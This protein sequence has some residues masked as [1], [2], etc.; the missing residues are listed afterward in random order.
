MK[1]ISSI[2]KVLS[3]SVS[4]TMILLAVRIIYTQKLV[5]GF[6]PWNLF[7]AF[8]PLIASSKLLNQ[9]RLN[10]KAVCLLMI[11]LLFFPNAPYLITDL[12][13]FTEREGCPPW[14]DLIL[15][16]SAT[17]NGI[18]IGALSLLQ[19]EKFLEKSFNHTKVR[20]ML[21]FFILLCGYGVYLG[22]FL[23]FNSWDIVTNPSNLAYFIKN[24]LLHPHQNISTWAFTIFFGLLFA[25]I[26]FTIKG[27]N[28]GKERN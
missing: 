15:V 21:L 23:R 3:L 7:L 4:F 10:W 2:G 8:I 28:Q 20:L 26:F 25:I 24:S 5:Y 18:I 17:W 12:F 13:H 9:N 14:F 27:L 16:S 6:Y 22:R 1:P 11:W 19:V